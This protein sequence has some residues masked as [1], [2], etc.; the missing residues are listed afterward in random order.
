MLAE[1]VYSGYVSCKCVRTCCS[2]D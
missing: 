2:V 1:L